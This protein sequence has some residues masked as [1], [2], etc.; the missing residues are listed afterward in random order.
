[1]IFLT[2][3]DE[4]WGLG[5]MQ[6]NMHEPWMHASAVRNFPTHREILGCP[7]WWTQPYG[8]PSCFFKP[9]MIESGFRVS[10]DM[11]MRIR[12]ASDAFQNS[13]GLSHPP[14]D[15]RMLPGWT[16][17]YKGL[18]G[19]LLLLLLLLFL[20]LFFTWGDC[21]W[22]LGVIRCGIRIQPWRCARTVRGF[23]LPA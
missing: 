3:G 18:S 9:G 20:V 22:V 7:L 2:L 12:P 16:E 5:V 13:Q 4:I 1:M 10:S 8:S 6:C 17:P 15:F 23:P 11:R 21:I 19:L 14:K